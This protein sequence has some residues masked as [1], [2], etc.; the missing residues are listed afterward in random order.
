MYLGIYMCTACVQELTD[1]RRG[2]ECPQ[3]RWLL[4]IMWVL[5]TKPWSSAETVT[6]FKSLL[7]PTPPYLLKPGPELLFHSQRLRY[8][9]CLIYL[10]CSRPSS[11]PPLPHLLGQ[12]KHNQS[13][14]AEPCWEFRTPLQ[15]VCKLH[16]Q[17]QSTQ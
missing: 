9:N 2:A 7:S 8:V 14:D 16:T 15:Q 11:G 6:A 12:L 17:G 1:I 13:Q 4:A 5:G 3:K 10:V